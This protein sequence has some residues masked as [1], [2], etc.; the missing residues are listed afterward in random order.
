MIKGIKGP[1]AKRKYTPVSS[2][3]RVD[4]F[5]LL[6]KVYKPC[7][8]FPDGGAMSQ[9][10][11]SLK[12]NDTIKLTYPFGRLNYEGKKVVAIKNPK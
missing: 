11:D 4:S 12:L 2:P 3:D 10:L 5:D 6:I 1:V 9:Y 8:K 7:E